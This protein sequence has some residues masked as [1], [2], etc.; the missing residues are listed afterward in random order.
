[1]PYPMNFP[2]FSNFFDKN[3]ACSTM[4]QFLGSSVVEQLAV[5]QLVVGSNPTRGAISLQTIIASW[6]F[7]YVQLTS[8]VRQLYYSEVSYFMGIQTQPITETPET[9]ERIETSEIRKGIILEFIARAEE[10]YEKWILEHKP[11]Q[12]LIKWIMDLYEAWLRQEEWIHL[13]TNFMRECLK[14]SRK[15]DAYEA[16]EKWNEITRSKTESHHMLIVIWKR[17]LNILSWQPIIR[18]SPPSREQ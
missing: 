8:R 15:L 16:Q 14:I 5:N 18:H 13:D 2:H 3:P 12:E 9:G 7:F 17:L 11:K 6:R 1:M 4:P 10:I